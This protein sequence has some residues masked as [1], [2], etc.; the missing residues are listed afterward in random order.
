MENGD[1]RPAIGIVNV[2]GAVEIVPANWD[3]EVTEVRSKP[4]LSLLLDSCEL[5]PRR[6]TVSMKAVQPPLPVLDIS[7]AF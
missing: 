7:E 2:L 4:S 6:T 1:M 3:D 5:K